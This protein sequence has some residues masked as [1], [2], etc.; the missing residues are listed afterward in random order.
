LN[1]HNF[2][3]E[4][5]HVPHKFYSYLTTIQQYLPAEYQQI[6]RL[7]LP[8][9]TKIDLY[10]Q[11]KLPND[12]C[13][14][15]LPIDVIEEIMKK[16][17]EPLLWVIYHIKNNTL[18]N[19]KKLNAAEHFNIY[20]YEIHS[21]LN[22]SSPRPMK[23]PS[24]ILRFFTG[25]LYS[26]EHLTSSLY[27]FQPGMRM[28]HARRIQNILTLI[29]HIYPT[30]TLKKLPFIVYKIPGSYD[31][32]EASMLSSFTLLYATTPEIFLRSSLRLLF[33]Q[34]YYRVPS[35]YLFT[36]LFY[37]EQFLKE[38]IER[39]GFPLTAIYQ[40]W[41]ELMVS[42]RNA[43]S[44]NTSMPSVEQQLLRIYHYTTELLSPYF[45]SIDDLPGTE[46]KEIRMVIKEATIE[47][48]RIGIRHFVPAV[49][50]FLKD[51]E[52]TEDD[53]IIM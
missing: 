3:I 6:L 28:I 43:S 51:I 44:L 17:D 39:I 37:S 50:I 31:Y 18:R 24:V 30:S 42:L 41:L 7:S 25:D 19:H 16:M 49:H 4:K 23:T 5:I 36:K 53:D 11:I 9:I 1:K 45:S 13:F 20:T 8:N 33:L 12:L 35:Y 21:K 14:I 47:L 10:D 32:A 48:Y 52:A 46:Y 2:N 22:I 29:A 26:P 27:D 40:I 15:D 38:E 34:P